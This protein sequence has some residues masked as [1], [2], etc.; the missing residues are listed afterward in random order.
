MDDHIDSTT[1]ICVNYFSRQ[2]GKKLG[3]IFLIHI[4]DIE[5]KTVVGHITYVLTALKWF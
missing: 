3:Q 1:L 2:V 4:P 5:T